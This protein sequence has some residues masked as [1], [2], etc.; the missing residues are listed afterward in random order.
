MGRQEFMPVLRTSSIFQ[1]DPNHNLTVAAMH[2]GPSGL[3]WLKPIDMKPGHRRTR[4]KPLGLGWR[5]NRI[6]NR[7]ADPSL[8]SVPTLDRRHDL[9]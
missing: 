5:F 9:R 3:S 8:L 1:T 7:R 6:G 2:N 4:E